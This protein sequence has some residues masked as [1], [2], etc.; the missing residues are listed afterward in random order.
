ML[1]KC[2]E[3]AHDVSDK[4]A[5]CPYCGC[6]VNSAFVSTV[7]ET[8]CIEKHFED[9]PTVAAEEPQRRFSKKTVVIVAVI[10]MLCVAAAIVFACL[11]GS[12]RV[13]AVLDDDSQRAYE[14]L[15]A[16]AYRFP[17]CETLRIKGG[18]IV[19]DEDMLFCKLSYRDL[20]AKTATCFCIIYPDTIKILDENTAISYID[21]FED[22]DFLDIAQINVKLAENLK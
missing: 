15:V 2:P 13:P 14:L 16:N 7:P 8:S 12:S 10:L 11:N 9:A 19:A 22:T 6:P 5:A 3:C 21:V 1:I 17:N 18:M 4:A 20:D